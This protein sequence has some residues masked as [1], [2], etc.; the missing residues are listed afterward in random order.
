MQRNTLYAIILF[1]GFAVATGALLVAAQSM[2]DAYARTVLISMGSAL[3]GAGLTVL[4]LRLLAATDA[5]Q[6]GA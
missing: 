4:V 1:C 5:N 6:K 2:A 3:F